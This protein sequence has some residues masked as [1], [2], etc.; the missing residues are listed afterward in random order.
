[1]IIIP[2]SGQDH[3]LQ[4]NHRPIDLLSTLSKIL[5]RII[6]KKLNDEQENRNILPQEQFGWQI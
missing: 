3:T 1:M 6:L 5:K 4:E 2:E